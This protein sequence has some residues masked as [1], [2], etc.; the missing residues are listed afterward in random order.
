[1]TGVQTCALPIPVQISE[2]LTVPV[3]GKISGSGTGTG[4]RKCPAVVPVLVPVL[5]VTEKPQKSKNE[6]GHIFRIRT[7]FLMILGSLD[8]QRKALQDHAEKH[9]CPSCEEEVTKRE[10]DLTKKDTPKKPP[11]PK[12]Q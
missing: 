4:H 7:P 3:P 6:S 9:H 12:T 8:S 11:T 2:E 10:F 5:P 1:M